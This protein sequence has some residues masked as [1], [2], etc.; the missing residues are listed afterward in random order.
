MKGIMTYHAGESIQ[1]FASRA[2]LSIESAYAI[3]HARGN[4]MARAWQNPADMPN[5]AT[6]EPHV[7]IAGGKC[8]GLTQADVRTIVNGK[9]TS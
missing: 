1:E 5:S 7:I 6:G 4:A 9:V 2:R 3:W 8:F